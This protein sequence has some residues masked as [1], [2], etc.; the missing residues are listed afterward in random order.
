MRRLTSR[1]SLEAQWGRGAVD[2]CGKTTKPVNGAF[3]RHVSRH[4][5]NSASHVSRLSGFSRAVENHCP[6]TQSSER[7]GVQHRLTETF[8]VVGGVKHG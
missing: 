5:R 8:V 6:F 1:V 7:N 2:G 3:S 4:Q